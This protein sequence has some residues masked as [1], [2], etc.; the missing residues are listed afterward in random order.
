MHD[1]ARFLVRPYGWLW[2]DLTKG[3]ESEAYGNSNPGEFYQGHIDACRLVANA[4]CGK[5]F[6]PPMRH[7]RCDTVDSQRGEVEWREASL[8][9]DAW[10]WDFEVELLSK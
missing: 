8:S 1:W 5:P 7:W 2:A 6:E 10:D 4:D 3:A 9:F